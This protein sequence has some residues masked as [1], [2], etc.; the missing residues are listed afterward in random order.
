M[1]RR[2]RSSCAGE[3]L[4]AL[5][6]CGR[7]WRLLG[8]WAAPRGAAGLRFLCAAGP[9]GKELSPQLSR[10]RAWLQ[11]GCLMLPDCRC[12]ASGAAG[13]GL[14][15]A[16]ARRVSDPATHPLLPL[17]PRLGACRILP[18]TCC[19]P[20]PCPFAAAPSWAR[21]PCCGWPRQSKNLCSRVWRR[22]PCPP[23]C[24]ASQVSAGGWSSAQ[25]VAVQHRRLSFRA[26]CAAVQSSMCSCCSELDVQLPKGLP[27]WSISSALAER[28]SATPYIICCSPRAPDGISRP[29]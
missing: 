10:W 28:T 9:D 1:A 22:G 19:C 13:A 12:L 23:C 14:A 29:C 20:C 8:C 27:K 26:R 5:W 21:R 4:P 25:A 16:A 2:C 17:P 24:A 11:P 18:L 3:A 15:T 7:G 6:S